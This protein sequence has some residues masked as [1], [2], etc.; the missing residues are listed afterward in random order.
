[1]NTANTYYISQ[2]V[3]TLIDYKSKG[4]NSRLI[5]DSKKDAADII[6]YKKEAAKKTVIMAKYKL[7]LSKPTAEFKKDFNLWLIM[8]AKL[9]DHDNIKNCS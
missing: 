5:I 7:E 2:I 9:V 4:Y 3:L 6:L 1:M 8:I